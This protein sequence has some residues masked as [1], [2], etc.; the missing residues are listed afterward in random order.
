MYLFYLN[1]LFFSLLLGEQN[2]PC[3]R[4]QPSPSSTSVPGF[5]NNGRQ[6]SMLVGTP[7]SCLQTC[8]VLVNRFGATPSTHLT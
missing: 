2:I 6:W 7:R 5:L 4:I 3:L 1:M 8:F